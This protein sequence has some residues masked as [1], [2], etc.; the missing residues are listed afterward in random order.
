MRFWRICTLWRSPLWTVI[1]EEWLKSF[2]SSPWW[3][4]TSTRLLPVWC[5]VAPWWPMRTSAS[6][7]VYTVWEP[8][9]GLRTFSTCWRHYPKQFCFPGDLLASLQRLY[10]QTEAYLKMIG[11]A[12]HAAFLPVIFKHPACRTGEFSSIFTTRRQV[13]SHI[14]RSGPRR[15]PGKSWRRKRPCVLPHEI[16]RTARKRKL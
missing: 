3:D 13:A 11:L 2:C 10:A 6:K 7:N 4:R 15:N 12:S 5:S 1:T 8:D 16:D 9:N 14:L